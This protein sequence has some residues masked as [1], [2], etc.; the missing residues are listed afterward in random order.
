MLVSSAELLSG[1]SP[2]QRRAV[3]TQSPTVCVVAA[4]G[5]GKT[6]V[7][8]RRIAYRA[9]SGMA[10]P[11]HTLAIT[12]TRKAAGELR[13]RLS[14]LGMHPGPGGAG[15]VWAGT[16]HSFCWAQLRRWWADR[17][18][19]EP[20]LLADKARLVGELASGRSG[21]DGVGVT[22]L[23]AAVE[24]AK[25]RSV[26]P[27]ELAAAARQAQRDL[28]ADPEA[29]AGLYA[30]YEDEKRRR[31]LVDYDDLLVRYAQALASDSRFAAAQRWRWAHVYVDE[32]QDLNP[33]QAR[34]L[35]E[36]VGD[37]DD[38]FVVGDPNQAIYGWNG[39]DPSFFLEFPKRWP[40]AE[41]VRLDDNHRSSPQVVAA[42]TAVLGHQGSAVRSSRPDGPLPSLTCFPS[43]LAEAAGVAESVLATYRR[44]LSWA[45]MA[46]LAR[47]NAQLV[48]VAEALRAAGVPVAV[49]G[50]AGA[51]GQGPDEPEQVSVCSFHRAKGLQWRAV[52]VCGLEEGFV[53]I[54]Y[55]ASP[56]S[57][58]EERRLLYVALSR[59]EAYLHCSWALERRAANGKA[60]R[61]SPS[62]WLATL[63]AHCSGA[64]V[65]PLDELAP[66]ALGGFGGPGRWGAGAA[67]DQSAHRAPRPGPTKH[68]VLAGASAQGSAGASPLT[69]AR[70]DPAQFLAQ[71]RRRLAN[72][73]PP[74]GSRRR[75]ASHSAELTARGRQVAEH[76][77]EW[78][79]RAARASGVPAHVLLHDS[80]VLAIARALPASSEDLL[81]VPGLGQVK[82]ARF[83]AE[84]L[85][86][87][88]GTSSA[89]PAE[90]AAH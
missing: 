44:G 70:V 54:A 77:L 83:G 81:D 11:E 82:A 32:L 36:L 87:V 42:A 71:A 3:E 1:L 39:A 15:P 33:L 41:V 56:A 45:Q 43:D 65:Q 89:E 72:A 80:T 31:R 38:L 66:G 2:M 21:L 7:L 59:A 35:R 49:P 63:A 46:V 13:E 48:S 26:A 19:G 76:L 52:W 73:R 78:R 61:R 47:T 28:P 17:R 37:N 24:W 55:A 14:G 88:A 4:A 85:S 90:R 16:F 30:R 62:P 68:E 20:V 67:T 27:A 69:S 79:R 12:F 8:T 18:T 60:V 57:L 29:I 40:D 84:I 10:K 53:P 23:V 50:E 86:V 51:S 64:L 74:L 34:V 6:R 58:A 25:A 9:L 22:E 75:P 5:A